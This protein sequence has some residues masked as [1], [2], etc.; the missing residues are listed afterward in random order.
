MEEKAQVE[1]LSDQSSDAKKT[2]KKDKKV[3][4]IVLTIVLSVVFFCLSFAGGFFANYLFRGR[5]ANVTYDIV[6]LMD[7]VGFIYDPITGEERAVT[8]KDVANALIDAFLDDYAA[9]YTKEEYQEIVANGQGNYKGIGVAF[10]DL[11]DNVVDVVMGNSPVHRNGMRKGDVIV[12]G[13][14]ENAQAIYFENAAEILYFLNACSDQ[15]IITLS[16]KNSRGEY[17]ITVQKESYITSYV[18]YYDSEKILTYQS[19]DGQSLNKTITDNLE[20]TLPQDTAYIILD[21]FEGGAAWQI[22]GALS[23]MKEQ[24]KTKLVLD[25]RNNGGGFMDT[26]TEIASYFIDNGGKKESVVAYSEGKTGTE[27]FS[28][29]KNNYSSFINSMAIIGNQS[30]ASASECLIGALVTYGTL[31]ISSVIVEKNSEGV[32]RT[33]GKGIMQTTYGLL[34]GGAFKLTTARILWPDKATCIHGKGI[35]AQMG[36]SVAELGKGLDKALEKLSA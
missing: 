16:Y 18:T 36:A 22:S 2:E 6:S 11:E 14:T 27:V 5:T 15:D 4:K 30:T 25:L 8:E 32:A 9:Y 19:S 13:K 26:L 35:T 28:T 23:F 21:S 20:I 3:V 24:G 1:K 10:Y 34:S 17:Q 7:N 31:D 29:D 33:Y 12:W